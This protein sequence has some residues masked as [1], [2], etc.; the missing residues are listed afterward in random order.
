M[1]FLDT[2]VF[3]ADHF[4]TGTAGEAVREIMP[5]VLQHEWGQPVTSSLVYAEAVTWTRR[6]KPF[7]PEHRIRESQR[8]GDRILGRGGFPKAVDLRFMDTHLFHRA[9]EIRRKYAEKPLSFTD[10]TIVAGCE[11]GG[12]EYVLTMD[13][14]LD[15]LDEVERRDPR[16]FAS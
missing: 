13:E 8:I 15:G 6:R 5:R 2:N 10:A 3:L 14:D 9:I 7:P 11:R 1:I 4:R 16:W 12:I